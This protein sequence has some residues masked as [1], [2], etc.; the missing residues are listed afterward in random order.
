MPTK[1]A[2]KKKRATR[3]R[4]LVVYVAHKR[5]A[6]P[7]RKAPQRW[8]AA[9]LMKVLREMA[10]LSGPV[11]GFAYCTF[12][13]RREGTDVRVD[14]ALAENVPVAPIAVI[15]LLTLPTVRDFDEIATRVWF[16]KK[17]NA[18]PPVNCPSP[19]AWLRLALGNKKG[20]GR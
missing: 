15:G 9:D 5:H 6:I 19:A 1:R 11:G 8:T 10:V 13:Y 12:R 4:Q 17:A 18:R 2:T 14:R 20:G 7:F 3:P 16:H